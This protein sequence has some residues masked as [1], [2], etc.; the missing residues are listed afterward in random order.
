MEEHEQQVELK[1][2]VGI[3]IILEKDSHQFSIVQNWASLL[4]VLVFLVEKV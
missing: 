3:G 4:F 1:K 2:C